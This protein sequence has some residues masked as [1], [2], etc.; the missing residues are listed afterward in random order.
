MVDRLELLTFRRQLLHDVRRVEDRLQIH[1]R[2]LD[3]Q[4]HVDAL[5]DVEEFGGPLLDLLHEGFVKRR[6][7]DRLRQHVLLVQNRVHL[8]RALQ[9]VG[10][11]GPVELLAVELNALPRRLHAG[12]LA[13]D[14]VLL[15]TAVPDVTD[16]LHI[17][18]QAEVDKVL[19]REVLHLGTDRFPYQLGNLGP[20]P[21]LHALVAHRHHQW[22]VLSKV[23][24]LILHLLG[25]AEDTLVAVPTQSERLRRLEQLLDA[26]VRSVFAVFCVDFRKVSVEVG[27]LLRLPV[28]RLLPQHREWLPVARHHSEVRIVPRFHAKQRFLQIEHLRRFLVRLE[29]F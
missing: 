10:L 15:P 19:Q 1:P 27:F 24:Q 11:R 16:L 23:S 13:F 12:Q 2:P 22:E 29:P 21:L 6:E 5:A 20:M 9:D 8:L 7:L 14:L 28:R 17:L 25:D 26:G 18:H 4:P 3:L